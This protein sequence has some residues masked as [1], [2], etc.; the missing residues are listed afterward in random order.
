LEKHL[1][2]LFTD[3]FRHLVGYIPPAVTSFVDA[4]QLILL[5]VYA[6]IAVAAY[7]KIIFMSL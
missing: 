7:C 3:P 5:R 1:D 4:L 2:V 6:A